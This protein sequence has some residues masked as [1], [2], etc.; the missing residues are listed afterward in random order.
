MDKNFRELTK[1][2]REVMQI[3]WELGVGFVND[4]I[5]KMSEPKP[6][7]NTVSTVSRILVNKGFLGYKAYGKSHQYY[8]VVS[9]E[10]YTEGMMHSVMQHYFDNSFKQLVSFFSQKEKVSIQEM[11]EILALL[12][13]EEDAKNL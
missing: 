10:E 11:E 12:K 2:E 8:P 13:K 7:Y 4:I 1:A 3:Y 6:A 9:K 5:D